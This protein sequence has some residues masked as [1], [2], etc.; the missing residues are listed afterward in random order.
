MKVLSIKSGLAY[1]VCAGIKDVENRTWKTDYRG[2]L[3]I[4]ACGDEKK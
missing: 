2:K 3:L 1:L 4:H